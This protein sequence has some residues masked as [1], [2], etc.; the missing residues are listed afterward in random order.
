[1][2]HQ[3]FDIGVAFIQDQQFRKHGSKM[4]RMQHRSG[5]GRQQLDERQAA[6]LNVTNITRVP[7][8]DYNGGFKR[9]GS[10]H[11]DGYA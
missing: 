1:M 5:K 2:L 3:T 4:Q 10:H 11:S 7:W 8:K 9:H 6:G